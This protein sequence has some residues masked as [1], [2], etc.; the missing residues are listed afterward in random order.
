MVFSLECKSGPDDGTPASG[1]LRLMMLWLMSVQHVHSC[2][3]FKNREGKARETV[4]PE[5]YSGI[6]EG[7]TVSSNAAIAG[8]STVC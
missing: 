5:A 6:R 4:K 8:F 7:L 2:R 3:P 1:P